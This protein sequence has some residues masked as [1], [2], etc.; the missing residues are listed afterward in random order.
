MHIFSNCRSPICK[1]N[2]VLKDGIQGRK[3]TQE[4]FCF[5]FYIANIALEY[6]QEYLSIV[7]WDSVAFNTFGFSPLIYF[8]VTFLNNKKNPLQTAS[9]PI[10]KYL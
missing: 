10:K 3:E 2:R 5:C 4:M 7:T 1:G 6:T 9:R 8:L